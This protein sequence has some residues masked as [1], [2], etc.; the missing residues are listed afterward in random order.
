[1]SLSAEVAKSLLQIQAI[2]LSPQSPFTWASGIKSPIYCDNRKTLSYPDIR[3]KIVEGFVELSKSYEPYDVVAG[4]ATAGI[5]HGALLAAAIDKP[6]VYVRSKPKGHGLKNMIEGYL[7]ENSSVL[8][9]EDL[10]STGMSSI[11]AV[12]ALREVGAN[13]KAV[14]AIFSYGFSK[15][16]TAFEESNCPFS[17]ISNYAELL[18]QAVEQEYINANQ[19]QI[20]LDWKENPSEWFDKNFK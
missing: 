20:L 2:K 14:A 5:A 16:T 8:V 6:F 10:I 4:V 11:K 3:K 12:D 7:P 17:T 18:T 13:V 15:A 1:M 9:V 19:H